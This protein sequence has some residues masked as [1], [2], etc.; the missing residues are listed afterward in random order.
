M[1]AT[2]IGMGLCVDDLSVT[3][4]STTAPPLKPGTIVEGDSGRWKFIYNY[5]TTTI[6]QYYPAIRLGTAT[7]GAACAGDDASVITNNIHG[8]AMTAIAS[9]EYGWVKC[10]GVMTCRVSTTAT[11][12]YACSC[13]GTY[14][15]AAAATTE[16]QVGVVVYG[17]AAAG[18]ALVDLRIA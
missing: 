2:L 1:S 7:A 4:S 10:G 16:M 11:A 13:I 12:G 5:G 14:L 15:K 9:S 3:F 17:T 6:T 18:T 8:I